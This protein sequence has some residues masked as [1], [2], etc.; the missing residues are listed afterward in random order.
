MS[1]RVLI[2][3]GLQAYPLLNKILDKQRNKNLD[4]LVLR[5]EKIEVS[6]AAFITPRKIIEKKTIIDEFDPDMILVPGLCK[7]DFSIVEDKTGRVTRKGT[8]SAGQLPILLSQLESLKS[9]LSAKKSA[10]RFLGMK[11]REETQKVL[12]SRQEDTTLFSS[13]KNFITRSGFTIGLS[14]PV[15][16]FAEI[17]DATLKTGEKLEKE[18]LYYERKGADVIDFGCVLS[19]KDPAA[20]ENK[21]AQI[22]RMTDLPISID[23]MD[24]AEIKAGLD[25]GAEFVISIDSGNRNVL[26]DLHGDPCLIL[27]PTNVKQGL[28]PESAVQRVD[29]LLAL[30]NDV[31]A[32]GF[33]KILADPVLEAPIIP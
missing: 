30:E 1:Y 3:T 15:R 18:V 24:P 31:R 5:I 2:F 10:D 6:V 22:R 29:A 14:F 19:N 33:T 11:Y 4:N 17:V 27:L 32:E 7:K 20:V 26:K 8:E 16:V 13:Q 12:K 21:I 25:A 23:S 9:V 28:F